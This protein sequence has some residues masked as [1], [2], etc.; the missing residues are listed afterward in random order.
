[1]IENKVLVTV[2]VPLLENSFDLYLPVNR[3]VY[4]VIDMIKQI[5]FNLSQGSFDVQSNCMLYDANSGSMYDI[6]SL[7]RDT[8]IRNGSIIILI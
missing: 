2:N 4:S 3:R 6:N 5:L 8:D 7:I 1:M